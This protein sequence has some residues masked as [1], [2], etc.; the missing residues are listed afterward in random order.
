MR[1]FF[2]YVMGRVLLLTGFT[3]LLFSGCTKMDPKIDAPSYIE[4]KDYQVITDSILQG[5]SN[6][7]FTDVLV[8]SATHNYGYYP[9]PGKIPVPLEGATYLSIRPALKVNGVSFLRLDYPVM[10]GCDSTLPL[11]KSKVLAVKPVF[12]YFS[13]VTFPVVEDFE[14]NTGFFIKNSSA[15]DTFCTKIDTAN[16]GFG[17]KCLSIKLNSQNTVCQIQSTSGFNL[18]NNGPNVYLE[19]NYKSNFAFEAGLIGSSSPGILGTDQRSAGGAKASGSWN[20]MYIDLTNLVRTP[21]YYSY[22]FLYFYTNTA[23]DGSVSAQQIYIDN[24]KVVSQH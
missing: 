19:F 3:F 14:K 2:I 4:I 13:T 21:P 8:S 23:F 24:I 22:Y 17:D 12:K 7:K 6:Q 20:K 5:T 9:I 15:T 16:A 1:S 11:E 10:K 18:P